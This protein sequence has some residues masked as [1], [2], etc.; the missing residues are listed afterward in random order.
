MQQ[1]SLTKQIE[2]YILQ[3]RETKMQK[4]DNDLAKKLQQG[5]ITEQQ[6]REARKQVQERFIPDVWLSDAAKRASQMTLTTH[7]LKFTHT[8]A[9][10]S[11]IY[12]DTASHT[13]VLSDYL[14]TSALSAPIV[15]VVGNAAALDVAGLLTLKTAKRSLYQALA[16]DDISDLAPFAKDQSQLHAWL[17]G[18][19]QV[20]IS[21]PSTH[22]LSKQNYFPVADGEYH[23]LGS[24]FASSLTQ[25]VYE[26]IS[27]N[28]FSEHH[29]GIRKQRREG[30]YSEYLAVS[31][32]HLAVQGFGGTQP[33]NVS[34]LNSKRGGRAYLFAAAPPE[35]QNQLAIPRSSAA[36]WR[37]YARQSKPVLKELVGSLKGVGA[38]NNIDIRHQRAEDIDEAIDIFLQHSTVIRAARDKAGWS[39]QTDMRLFEQ[40]WLDPH[41]QN[42]TLQQARQSDDWIIALAKCFAGELDKQLRYH[43]LKNVANPEHQTWFKSIK[44]SI[45]DEVRGFDE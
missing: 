3:R 13:E 36:F 45:I 26:K 28:R 2:D 7:A 41:C 39:T 8:D 18:F 12:L 31:Y 24:L 42:E 27:D 33:Q 11:S 4:V 38:A 30:C 17:N 44:K 21:T 5:A 29:K 40:C 6:Q 15:D 1:P 34:Q 10:G 35:W 43:G 23:L 37:S 16:A 22:T 9:K 14:D 20:F 19:K 32:H 25:A